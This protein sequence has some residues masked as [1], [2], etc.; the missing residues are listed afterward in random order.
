MDLT[1]RELAA[2]LAE[3]SDLDQPFGV[4]LLA[5]NEP[6]A[7]LGRAIEH[8]VF[9]EF[10][11]NTPELLT[12]EYSRYEPSSLFLCVVDHR[13]LV[14]AGVMRLIVPSPQ[15]LKSLDDIERVWGEPADDVVSRSRTAIDRN[16]CWDI[17]TLAVATE[18]RGGGTE[19]LVSL[20]LYQ[21][22]VMVAKARNVRWYVAILDTAVVDLISDRMAEPFTRFEG[23]E[24]RRY[25]DSPASLPVFVDLE[26]YGQRIRDR[27]PA[28]YEIL[29]DG[30]GLEAA[31]WTANWDDAVNRALSSLGLSHQD[32][33]VTSTRSEARS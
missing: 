1:L 20:A 27:D 31:V 21:A 15:G 10:F 9:G 33:S 14:P 3:L 2:P 32:N 30:T 25:L 26:T 8:E 29:F 17:A 4:H 18:Y 6:A 19:G 13:R 16:R 12:A 22:C 11:G 28:I 7:E 23:L 24:P 5:S